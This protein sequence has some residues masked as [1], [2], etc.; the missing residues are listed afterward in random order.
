MNK[1]LKII[2]FS[3]IAFVVLS[4]G[5]T[6]NANS[7][8]KISMDIFV[9]DNGDAT[10]QEVWNCNINQGT[11]EYHPY[12]NLGNSKITNL[13]VS[14]N[15][16]TF[17]NIGDW[18]T[19]KS[20]TEKANKCGINEVQNGIELCWGIGSYGSHIFKVNYKITNF[21][22]E[23]TDSQMIY[24]TLMPQNF[25]SS[26][27]KVYIKIHTNFNISNSV[28]VWGYGNYGGT[29]YV[30]NGYIEM[31]SKGA[32]DTSEHM[33]ILVQFPKGTF[34]CKNKLND[35][36][37]YYHNMA[38]QGASNAGKN[39]GTFI[40]FFIIITTITIFMVIGFAR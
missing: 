37:E 16:K 33:T 26:M 34:N 40:S 15:G 27:G 30:Y 24:W 22:S 23:L 1:S 14:E 12:Y 20:I 28:G 38:E 39:G 8:E 35:D 10:V 31:Q 11:E 6:V 13:N 29:A 17:T 18:D 36:F 9:D 32:L 5:K 4:I 21:V 7:I 19:S 3:V 25:S 2:L